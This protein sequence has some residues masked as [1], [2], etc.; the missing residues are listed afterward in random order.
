MDYWDFVIRRVKVLRK[1][2][3]VQEEVV[4]VKESLVV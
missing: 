3:M 4:V 2:V 1:G